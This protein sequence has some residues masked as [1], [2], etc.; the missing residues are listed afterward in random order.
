VKKEK[1]FFTF[2]LIFIFK[3]RNI[4][5]TAKK[6]PVAK[7]ATAKKTQFPIFQEF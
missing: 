6:K 5:A 2:H 7:K 1:N 4:M 3:E